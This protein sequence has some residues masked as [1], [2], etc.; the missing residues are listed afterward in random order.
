[1][2][3]HGHGRDCTHRLRLCCGEQ[4]GLALCGQVLN[5]GIELLLKAHVQ[6]AVGFVQHQHLQGTGI[7]AWRLLQVL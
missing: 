1:M 3:T 4:Q 5:D 2:G 7:E 6:Q